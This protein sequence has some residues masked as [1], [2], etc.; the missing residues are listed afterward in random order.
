MPSRELF[1][2][3]Q[4]AARAELTEAL[5][6]DGAKKEK[7]EKAIE[8]IS[9]DVAIFRFERDRQ[10]D[11]ELEIERVTEALC[12][13]LTRIESLSEL[14]RKTIKVRLLRRRSGA[15]GLPPMTPREAFDL[16]EQALPYLRGSLSIRSK[17]KG[18]PPDEKLHHLIHETAKAWKGASD[19]LPTGGRD[20]RGEP[21][22]KLFEFLKA[23]LGADLTAITWVRSLEALRDISDAPKRRR[24]RPRK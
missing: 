3:V 18:R 12:E 15:S 14:A 16:V 5:R 7:A 17:K 10:V 1:N 4:R 20:D 2:E 13:A 19:Q 23:Q 21:R 22:A 9:R 6:D 24:G 11:P 8:D